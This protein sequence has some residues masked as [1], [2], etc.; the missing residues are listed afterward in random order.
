MRSLLNNGAELTVD[1]FCAIV[2]SDRPNAVQLI[3][4]LEERRE[5]RDLE[6]RMQE[7][8]RMEVYD[9]ELSSVENAS[10]KTHM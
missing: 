5:C 6:A 7:S 2:K 3:H 8:L 4:E 1:A 9:I 10:R